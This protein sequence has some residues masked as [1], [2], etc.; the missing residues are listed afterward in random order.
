[1]SLPLRQYARHRRSAG[2]S[3]GTLSAVRAA[4]EAGRLARSVASDGSIADA[5]AA[6]LEWAE[7]THSDRVPLNGPTNGGE[8]APSSLQAARLRTELARAETA[9]IELRKL[10][11]QLID[12]GEVHFG[13]VNVFTIVK[14]RLRGVP[15]RL[16]QRWPDGK[17][18]LQVIALASELI[19]EALTELAERDLVGAPLVDRTTDDDDD[20]AAEA[21]T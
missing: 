19:D 6:D 5:E 7:T 11:G 10:K 9:E 2:L 4:I 12:V 13:L 8:R 1:M 21:T 15:S 17:P 18:N 14:T 3:G 20:D 16:A